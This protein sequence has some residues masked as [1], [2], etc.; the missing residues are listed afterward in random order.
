MTTAI[1]IDWTDEEAAA[2]QM[3]GNW[4][5]FQCFCW[6]RGYDLPDADAWCI[7]Y[8]SN[9]GSGL[10][11]ESNEAV[12]NKRLEPFSEGEDADLV[13]ERHSHWAVGHV[14]GF[15]IR[16][17]QDDGSVTPAFVE[18]CSIKDRLEDCPILAEQDYTER[19]F[20]ATLENYCGEMCRL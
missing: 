10:L 8:T 15:S 1:C 3:A 16:V 4:R 17:F 20:E 11:A 13:F 14:D 19:E 12:I 7:W 6:H 2:K 9:R 5:Q 18:F